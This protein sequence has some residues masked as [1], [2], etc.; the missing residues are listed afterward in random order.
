M[1]SETTSLVGLNFEDYQV[2]K[3]LSDGR[4]AWVYKARDMLTDGEASVLKIAKPPEL[5]QPHANPFQTSCLSVQEGFVAEI[6]PDT[7]WLLR[8]MRHIM[9][10]AT[11]CEWVPGGRFFAQAALPYFSEVLLD[12]PTLRECMESQSPLSIQLF[13]E[14]ARSLNC[15]PCRCELQ[16]GD[17]KPDNVIITPDTPWWINPGYYGTM[18]TAGNDFLECVVTT[19]IYNPFLKP[20][21]LFSFGVMLWEA[22]CRQHPLLI[23]ADGS[24]TRV[25]DTVHKWV[26]S[27]ENVGQYFLSPLLNLRRPI[28]LNPDIAP[29]LE[30]VLLQ[31]LRLQLSETG[32]IERGPGFESFEQ[33]RTALAKLQT[34]G[35]VNV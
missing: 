31:G 1:N 10:M 30:N 6:V 17:V 21:D 12:G 13:A 2:E 32:L 14:I 35:L 25:G 18:K 22:S 4:F 28:E 8:E 29:D 16:H 11:H 9:V 34:L 3:L 26:R 15:R 19:P 24:P 33:W 27:Y 23:A 5:I 20:D 7:S